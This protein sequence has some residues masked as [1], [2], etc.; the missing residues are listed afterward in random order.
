MR[1]DI[2]T[3]AAYEKN[4]F[5]EADNPPSVVVLK[6]KGGTI[7]KCIKECERGCRYKS[8]EHHNTTCFG[9][10]RIPNVILE[11]AKREDTKIPPTLEMFRF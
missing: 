9:I 10:S 11:T 3:A 5:T 7:T 1:H 4:I 2:I 8:D 6:L